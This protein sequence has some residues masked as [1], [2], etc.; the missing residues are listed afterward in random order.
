V[1]QKGWDGKKKI[2][3]E[4]VDV[5]PTEVDIHPTEVDIHPTENIYNLNI[6]ITRLKYLSLIG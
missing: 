4:E 2:L 5:H 3:Q 6:S 1:C